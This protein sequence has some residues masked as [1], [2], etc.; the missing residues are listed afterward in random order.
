MFNK[1]LGSLQNVTSSLN[2]TTRLKK[3]QN[4]IEANLSN[5]KRG[6]NVAQYN[7]KDFDHFCSKVMWSLLGF[8]IRVLTSTVLRRI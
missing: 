7:W 4:V 1:T 8:S 3:W 5:L 2:M 6:F